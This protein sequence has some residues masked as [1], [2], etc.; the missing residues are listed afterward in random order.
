ME[1]KEKMITNT[2]MN[3]N[4]SYK[5]F[6]NFEIK[7]I[8]TESE[9]HAT[10]Y[11]FTIPKE[12]KTLT[13]TENITKC[14]V[15]MM[16]ILSALEN[17][18][19][20]N[21]IENL[22]GKFEF[23]SNTKEMVFN[24]NK[25]KEDNIW[26][27]LNRLLKNTLILKNNK[28]KEEE[29]HLQD[30]SSFLTESSVLKEKK[31]M[32]EPNL[33]SFVDSMASKSCIKV[34]NNATIENKDSIVALFTGMTEELKKVDYNKGQGFFLLPNSL[35]EIKK[36]NTIRDRV[37]GVALVSVIVGV[38]YFFMRKEEF[39]NDDETES[40][41]I[42]KDNND[43]RDQNDKNQNNLKVENDKTESDEIN[44]DNN[45]NKDQNDKNQNNLKGL[46][47]T[48]EK[49]CEIRK[50]SIKCIEEVLSQY[51]N[52]VEKNDEDLIK[53]ISILKKK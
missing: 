51:K 45:D 4:E 24:F 30:N 7:T 23:I 16:Y 49:G 42:N 36:D 40:D 29:N 31:I 50:E 52:K 3:K 46:L 28:I 25:D 32:V 17:T 2:G 35:F 43:N 20:I 27:Q 1:N 47:D 39:K 11:E 48:L 8:Q 22:F 9:P 38:T 12:L 15:L 41:E 26:P 14:L 18:G 44:K 10:G 19:N 34:E 33:L 6:Q 21:D 53:I 13:M 5:P 37:I